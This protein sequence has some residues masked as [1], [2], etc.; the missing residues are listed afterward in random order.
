M[1]TGQCLPAA[2]VRAVLAAEGQNPIIVGNRSG[3]GYPTALI[4]TSNAD[5]SKGYMLRGD[6]PFGQQ[7]DTVCIDSVFTDIGLND[8]SKPGIPAWARVNENRTAAEA[9]CRRDHLGYQET[10]GL[11]GDAVKNQTENGQPVLFAALGTAINPR[12]KSIRSGQL[13]VVTYGSGLNGGLV[14]ATTSNGANYMLSAYS[15]VKLTQNAGG[16]LTAR[17]R[18]R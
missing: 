3:Y 17:S 15:D 8:V 7:A 14:T 10:C 18:D 9:E 12:D 16:V 5:G 6:K 1:D 4:L 13:I 11:H 2:Q